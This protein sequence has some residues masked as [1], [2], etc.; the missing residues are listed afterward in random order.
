MGAAPNRSGAAV[1]GN[2]GA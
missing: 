1:G 2:K